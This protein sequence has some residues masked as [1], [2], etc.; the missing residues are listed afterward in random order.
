VFNSALPNRFHAEDS[1]VNVPNPNPEQRDDVKVSEEV[2][3]RLRASLH[4]HGKGPYFAGKKAGRKWASETAEAYELKRLERFREEQSCLNPTDDALYRIVARAAQ[5]KDLTKRGIHAFWE[6]CL[7]CG[8]DWA[9]PYEVTDPEL[10]TGFL[11][12]AVELW[13][14]VKAR[15]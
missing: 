3:Q 9:L 6:D 13:R 15:I 4:E 8:L 7:G 10:I 11:D 1:L 5:G 14:E 2:V 12:G